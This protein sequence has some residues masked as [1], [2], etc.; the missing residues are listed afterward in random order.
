ME[1]DR[2][3][4]FSMHSVV[5]LLLLSC[6]FSVKLRSIMKLVINILRC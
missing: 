1:T 3:F 6:L 5:K 4:D 2:I